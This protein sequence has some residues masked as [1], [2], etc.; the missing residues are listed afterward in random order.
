MR[1]PYFA[2]DQKFTDD[3]IKSYFTTRP[4]DYARYLDLKKSKVLNDIPELRWCIRQGCGKYVISNEG[5]THVKC[6][7]G[8]EFCFNCRENWHEGKTCEEQ[9]NEDFKKLT[10]NRLVK[11]CP[12]CKTRTE[13]DEGCDHMTCSS[14]QY[15]YCWLCLERYTYDHFVIDSQ[16]RCSVKNWGASVRTVRTRQNCFK[17]MAVIGYILLGILGMS[18]CLACIPFE[19]K[20]C[21]S[22][23]CSACYQKS[24]KNK[25][26]LGFLI[27]LG[28]LLVPLPFLALL[29]CALF[30]ICCK[31]KWCDDW[32]DEFALQLNSWFPLIVH[33]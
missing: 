31:R 17:C 20:A 1:C 25:C 27:V 19:L 28:A 12:K 2:C 14:C 18:V 16:N 24:E 33:G 10:Q 8:Q 13:K 7:C 23:S 21:S 30:S 26:W 29:V 3:E 15:E 6:E 32:V 4:A 11:L 22:A 9:I 5:N